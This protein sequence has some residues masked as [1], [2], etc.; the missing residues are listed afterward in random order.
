M[1]QPRYNSVFWLIQC[2]FVKMY[3]RKGSPLLVI[4]LLVM[5]QFVSAGEDKT[6][7]QLNVVS[8]GYVKFSGTVVD[9]SHYFSEVQVKPSS[10]QKPGPTISLGTLGLNSNV[11]GDC[12]LNFSTDNNF[13]LR[14]VSSNTKLS[15]YL[16]NYR[17]KNISGKQNKKMSV[18]CNYKPEKIKFN[19][20]GQYLAEV[21]PGMYSDTVRVEVVTQ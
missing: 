17:N 5:T 20:T 12:T 4:S 2:K 15:D 16:L 19:T 14:H 10:S 1:P 3:L 6:S 9:T 11:S 21:E 8:P 13:G 7:I 18:P